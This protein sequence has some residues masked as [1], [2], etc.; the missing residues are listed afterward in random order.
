VKTISVFREATGESSEQNSFLKRITEKKRVIIER[1]LSQSAIKKRKS[2]SS[3]VPQ[4]L[5]SSTF[6]SPGFCDAPASIEAQPQLGVIRLSRGR[7]REAQPCFR[8]AIQL[9]PNLVEVYLG[10]A[11]VLRADGH[12]QA[13]AR[14]LRRALALQPEEPLRRKLLDQLKLADSP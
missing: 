4:F 2:V 12:N 8:A 13:A 7:A 11:V 10:L 9:K 6:N 3:S 1:I 5:A 14:E